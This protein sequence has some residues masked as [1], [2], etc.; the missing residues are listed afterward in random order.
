MRRPIRSRYGILAVNWREP[1][2]YSYTE[3]LD[4]RQWAWEFMRRNT[5]YQQD[6]A[7]FI[8]T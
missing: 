2:T 3:T 1:E 8:K 7:W 6:Y 4:A 5:D